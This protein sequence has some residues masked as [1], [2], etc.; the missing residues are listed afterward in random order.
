MKDAKGNPTVLLVLPLAYQDGRDKYAGFLHYVSERRPDWDIRLERERP[1][2]ARARQL[3]KERVDA[4]V[5]DG[6][7]DTSV[8][9][10]L[11]RAPVRV[12]LDVPDRSL[13]PS[14]EAATA[15]AE[16]DSG[17]LGQRAGDYLLARSG[18][19][20][21]AFVGYAAA[22]W[23]TRRRAAFMERLAAAGRVP[24]VLELPFHGEQSATSR[25]NLLHLLTGLSRPAGVFAACDQLARWVVQTAGEAGLSVPNDLAVLGVDNEDIICTHARPTLSSLQPDFTALGYEAARLLD[26]LLATGTPPDAETR[27]G[28]VRLVE[29]ESTAPAYS[30]AFLVAQAKDRIRHGPDRNPHVADVARALGVSRRLLDLRFREATGETVLDFLRREKLAQAK[31][32]LAETGMPVGAVCEACGFRSTNHLKRIFRAETGLS[33]RAW[34]AAQQTSATIS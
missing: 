29:R 15:F 20:D 13:F 18:T 11:S 5:L 24:K 7:L 33:M 19:A 17:E 6:A 34:R 12:V 25:R 22:S 10:S 2:P 31:R 16:I 21:M 9:R 14:S 26:R 1:T 8:C 4:V 28:G 30:A 32:L 27:V 23:S 3:M